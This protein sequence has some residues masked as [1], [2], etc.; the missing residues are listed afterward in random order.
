MAADEA[1]LLRYPFYSVPTLRIYGWEPAC[2]SLGYNQKPQN[3]LTV[4]KNYVRRITGGSA[5][6]HHQELTYS[7]TCSPNDLILP[8]QVK[9]SYC[10]LCGFLLEFYS[11]LGLHADF[12]QNIFKNDLGQYGSFCF[13]SREHFDIIIK[14]KK[15][16]GN[17][18][19]RNKNIIFQHGSIPQKIDFTMIQE[20]IHNVGS[21]K[22]NT[23]G[24]DDALGKV[25]EFSCLQELLSESF[26]KVFNKKFIRGG[27]SSEEKDIIEKLQYSKYRQ[28]SWNENRIYENECI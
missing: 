9:E 18:Q 26:K 16:G 27:F 13:S 10:V 15:I 25:T 2:I 17:A 11:R 3:V 23:I 19:K 28:Q 1:I 5:I 22:D 7:I 6:Y 8:K 20:L 21:L 4:K 24:L 14:G 12:A